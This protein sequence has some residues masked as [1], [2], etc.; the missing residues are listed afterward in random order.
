MNIKELLAEQFPN[1][2]AICVLTRFFGNFD[3]YNFTKSWKLNYERSKKYKRIIIVSIDKENRGAY[4]IADIKE[5]IS[6]LELKQKQYKN[7]LTDIYKKI[8]EKDIN[9]FNDN[10]LFSNKNIEISH[11]NRLVIIFN[12]KTIIKGKLEKY[13][14][15][16]SNPAFYIQRHTATKK[17]L[18]ISEINISNFLNFNQIKQTF[19]PDLSIKLQNIFQSEDRIGTIRCKSNNN[20]LKSKLI[21]NDEELNKKNI[22]FDIGKSTETKIS[23]LSFSDAISQSFFSNSVFIPT[24]EVLSIAKAIRKVNEFIIDGFDHT[25]TDLIKDILPPSYLSTNS[26]VF[27]KIIKHFKEEIHSGEIEYDKNKEKYYYKKTDGQSYDITMTA[28]GVKQLGIIPLLIKI[29]IIN[30]GTILFL[31]EP[32]NNL[33]PVAITKFINILTL[34]S[35][36]NVQIF[37]TTHNY[38]VINRLHINA[39][40][41]K[42]LNFKMFSLKDKDKIE[43]E[44]ENLKLCLPDNPII[45]ESLKMFDDEIKL[46]L[47]L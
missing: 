25:Y 7:E 24:K 40:I 37:L 42:D 36:A 14:K 27:E 4:L 46:D 43:I 32:D 38:F 2:N 18:K 13:F 15:S 47:E 23:N 16:L 3:K 39:K 5:I 20:D 6:L 22:T 19:S 45:N 41:N 17:L 21:F 35:K 26:D 31:D 34:H 33:N 44:T 1:E 29:G 9:D 30:K 28:E 10:S 12:K 8:I 11:N